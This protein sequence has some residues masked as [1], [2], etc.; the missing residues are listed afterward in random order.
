[1]AFETNIAALDSELRTELAIK[2]LTKSSYFAAELAWAT[3]LRQ[4]RTSTL[5][6]L[7]P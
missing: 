3:L 7:T 4:E 5:R 1:M 2:G 6:S